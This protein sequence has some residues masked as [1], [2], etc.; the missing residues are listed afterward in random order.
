MVEGVVLMG[1]GR[2][3]F[4]RGGDLCVGSRIEEAGVPG[5]H[6]RVAGDSS[7]CTTCGSRWDTNAEED[8][9]PPNCQLQIDP[10]R[11]GLL[12]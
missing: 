12:S 8:N 1:Y 3:D 10:F 7:W 5:C 4:E 2:I 9:R 11:R 6:V